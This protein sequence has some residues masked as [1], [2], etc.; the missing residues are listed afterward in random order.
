MVIRRV[1]DGEITPRFTMPSRS[2]HLALCAFT[3]LAFITLGR[4]PRLIVVGARDLRP[5]SVVLETEG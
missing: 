1:F 4:A 3:A 5:I 2:R